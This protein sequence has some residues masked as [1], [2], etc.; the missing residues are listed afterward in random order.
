[1]STYQPGYHPYVE[2]PTRAEAEADAALDT[3]L[4]PNPDTRLC[5][6]AWITHDRESWAACDFC[7]GRLPICR[8]AN[9]RCQHGSFIDD[10]ETEWD[11][12]IKR[13]TCAAETRNE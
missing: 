1:M 3:P 13:H 12:E 7:Q 10:P 11:P 6:A 5:I 2:P 8:W 9:D 4:Q